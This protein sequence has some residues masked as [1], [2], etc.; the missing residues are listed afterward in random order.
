MSEARVCP[1]TGEPHMTSLQATLHTVI[2]LA[3]TMPDPH[4]M[5]LGIR[6]ADP[7][8]FGHGG[9][10]DGLPAC[11]KCSA[12]GQVVELTWTSSCEGYEI[13]CGTCYQNHN[14]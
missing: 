10:S 14:M 5:I 1:I 6:A 13:Y 4:A 7:S 12:C 8:R 3:A 2:Q 11:V 9:A